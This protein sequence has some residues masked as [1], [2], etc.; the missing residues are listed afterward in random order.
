MEKIMEDSLRELKDRTVRNQETINA[1]KDSIKNNRSNLEELDRKIEEYHTN[2]DAVSGLIQ[3]EIQVIKKNLPNEQNMT[4]EE[5][6]RMEENLKKYNE[7]KMK[8]VEK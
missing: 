7:Q 3:S 6:Q 1:I 4:E 5:K 8:V 2:L